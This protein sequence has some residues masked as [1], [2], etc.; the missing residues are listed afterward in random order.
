VSNCVVVGDKQKHLACLLTI[1]SVPDPL[2]MEA[3]PQMDAAAW[4]WCR[5]LGCKP[6]SIPD[7]VQN[8]QNYEAV[9]DG[10]MEA[11]ETVNK[12]SSSKAAKVR[13]F[14]ILPSEFS[15]GGGEL[16]PTMKIKRHVVE[17]KYKK[18]IDLMYST[19][20]RTSLWDA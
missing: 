20:D 16:G 4:E 5:S 14:V 18:E 2:T 7:L 3:T 17:N 1:R 12:G 13:K 15:I 6:E 10:V 19:D 11:L 8:R 9:W